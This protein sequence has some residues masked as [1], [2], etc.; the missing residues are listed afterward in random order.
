MRLRNRIDLVWCFVSSFLLFYSSSKA[1]QP[2]HSNCACVLANVGTKLNKNTLGITK[3]TQ[4]K[5]QCKH[6]ADITGRLS[7]AARCS[8]TT[9]TVSKCT[10]QA[11]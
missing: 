8:L 11:V 9:L 5:P 4:P 7:Q 6:E 1:I 10:Y 3:A 2:S